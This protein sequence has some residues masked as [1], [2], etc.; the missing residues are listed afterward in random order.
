MQAINSSLISFANSRLSS[1]HSGRH[2]PNSGVQ[3]DNTLNNLFIS[4]TASSFDNDGDVHLSTGEGDG[5]G[6]K[7]GDST[8]SLLLSSGDKC[9]T[10][11]PNGGG[12]DVSCGNSVSHRNG[13]G[14]KVGDST[15]SLLLSS[16]DKCATSLPN[17]DSADVCDGDGEKISNG[18]CEKV[19]NGV[20]EKVGN[21]VGTSVASQV[22]RIPIIPVV[23]N[24]PN[25]IIFFVFI[26]FSFFMFVY[27]NSKTF[28]RILYL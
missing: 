27:I 23:Y 12:A 13:V 22:L 2:S 24:N 5:V 4:G 19:G 10:S 6:E 3:R 26:L 25:V 1:S 14:E 9:A 8:F 15:F 16:G 20:G 11:L 7:V 18:D 28:I 17:G 21:G